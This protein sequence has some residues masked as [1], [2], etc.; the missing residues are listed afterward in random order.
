MNVIEPTFAP[1][2]RVMAYRFDAPLGKAE[3]AIVL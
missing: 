3:A 2:Q 1:A